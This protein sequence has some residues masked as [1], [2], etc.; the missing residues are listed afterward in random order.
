L[1]SSSLSFVF[2]ESEVISLS[3]SFR[4]EG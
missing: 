1:N 4:F 3:C 2:F